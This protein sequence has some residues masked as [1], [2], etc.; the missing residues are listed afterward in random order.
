MKKL[1]ALMLFSSILLITTAAPINAQ[2]IL[3]I[4]TN[5]TGSSY[6]VIGAGIATIVEKYTPIKMKVIPMDA[7]HAWM[8]L[9]VTGQMDLGIASNWNAEKGYLGQ[10]FYKDL[11]KGKGFPVRL[12]FISVP[13]VIGLVVVGSS[14]IKKIPDLKGK[15]VAGPIPNE[16][17]QL[18]TE[19]LLADGGLKWSDIKPLPV[20]SITD[21]VKAVIDGRADAAS[22][23][24]G[25]PL[26]EE[27][28]AKKGARFLPVDPSPEAIK[29]AKSV[30]PGY[31]YKVSPGPAKTGI[32]KEQYL[33][34]Y[35][36]YIIVRKD[37]SESIMYQVTK[38]LWDHV[39]ELASF[40]SG[41]KDLKTGTFVSEEAL[42]P[43]HP[44]AIK[45]YKEK[46]V[47]TKE[48]EALQKKLLE[49]KKD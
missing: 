10:A 24:L 22:I 11:S 13:N 17:M 3:N 41:L 25:T 40:H 30:Y 4:G 2:E 6:H 28:Q 34:A 26:V 29:R 20:K 45:L 1:V 27:L 44:G 35:D 18:Q 49:A 21:G 15:R 9:M 43:Y 19:S 38:A 32:A 8:P 39:S 31:A 14:D 46:G 23:A 42:I 48:M 12:V 37:L 5:P 33:W 36:N 7:A 16:A 47:W